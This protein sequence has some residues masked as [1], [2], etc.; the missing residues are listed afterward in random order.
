MKK[1]IFAKSNDIK[2]RKSSGVEDYSGYQ[3]W[4]ENNQL[5]NEMN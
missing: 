3:H 2:G 4:R 5:G 1:V